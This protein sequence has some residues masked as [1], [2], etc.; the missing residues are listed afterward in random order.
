MKFSAFL[1][2]SFPI[3]EPTLYRW[4][5]EIKEGNV[6]LS[7]E[8]AT[9]A[10]RALT[11]EQEQC[12]A[13]WFLSMEDRNIDTRRDDYAHIARAMFGVQ[14]SPATASRNLHAAE[15]SYKLKGP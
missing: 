6:P 15:L 2:A 12:I 14:V 13:G 8:K 3:S 10:A 1:A 7:A 9:G 4:M 11:E 5:K